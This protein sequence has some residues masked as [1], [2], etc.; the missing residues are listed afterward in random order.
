MTM[1]IANLAGEHL[2]EP[3][4]LWFR[5][6]GTFAAPLFVTLS[7]MM[8]MMGIQSKS[9][10]FLYFLKRGLWILGVAACLDLFIWRSY[11]FTCVDV[12]YLIGVATP[13]TYLFAKL[14]PKVRWVLIVGVVALAIPLRHIWGYCEVP[15]LVSLTQPLPYAHYFSAIWRHW[16]ID[17]W[18]PLLP[19]IAFMWLGVQL[20]SLR[21]TLHTYLRRIFLIGVLLYAGGVAGLSQHV[22]F[23]RDG[24]SELFYPLGPSFFLAAVGCMLVLYALIQRFR[25]EKFSKIVTL[26]GKRSLFIYIAH[27]VIIVYLIP[28][29]K[30][31]A[32][33]PFW[34]YCAFTLLVLWGSAVILNAC[35]DKF[36]QK[37]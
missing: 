17:G 21:P 2:Q 20:E 37:I 27:L 10:P 33:G 8:I 3:H 34:I 16:L 23:I 14:R 15:T 9:R 7:G 13:I 25:F 35:N 29:S 26:F 30:K 12:L 5:Y 31:I 4:P 32:F 36:N 24:Y 6:I 18:F 22:P 28:H 1:V 11:P 19:W